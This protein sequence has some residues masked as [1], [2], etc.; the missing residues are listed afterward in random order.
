MKLVNE[1]VL[2]HAIWTVT[3]ASL[4]AV[5]D[6]NRRHSQE[7]EKVEARVVKFAEVAAHAMYFR[8]P[9]SFSITS[10]RWSWR[11]SWWYSKRTW[12]SRSA[13]G[14]GG[15]LGPIIKECKGWRRWP[16]GLISSVLRCNQLMM[17]SGIFFPEHN[18]SNVVLKKF[19]SWSWTGFPKEHPSSGFSAG[20]KD[21]E[22]ASEGALE[23]HTELEMHIRQ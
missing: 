13:R 7:L 8:V 22:I 12:R 4:L 17:T 14:S 10:R 3:V 11:P 2:A 18:G 20:R 9:L 6:H 5:A 16:I 1:G 15:P 23:N 19:A 21:V